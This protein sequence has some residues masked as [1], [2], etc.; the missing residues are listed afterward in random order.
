VVIRREPSDRFGFIAGLVP[1]HTRDFGGIDWTP[2]PV[3]L[4]AVKVAQLQR[5]KALLAPY[6]QP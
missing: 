5:F 4:T 3:D 1:V 2:A 6:L